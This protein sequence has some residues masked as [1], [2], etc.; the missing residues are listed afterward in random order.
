M[1]TYSD[2]PQG[3]DEW[4]AERA[5]LLTASNAKKMM[6]GKTTATYKS[7]VDDLWEERV[8]G[9]VPSNGFVSAAMVE[10]SEREPEARAALAWD[11]N[12]DIEEVGLA[13]NSSYPGAGA[14]LDGLIDGSIGVEIKVRKLSRLRD[15][16]DYTHQ[17]MFQMMICD[18]EAVYYWG[19]PKLYPNAA[20]Q[21]TPFLHLIERDEDKIS[22]MRERY[23]ETNKLINEK[24]Q[25]EIDRNE[26]ETG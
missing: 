24:A 17:I 19:Y 18:L 22:L 8:C 4:L 15:W 5:G 23:L 7:Y 14:S 2:I 11:L 10:G 25:K 16:K 13:T 9:Y 12:R 26:H 1:I 21:P 3:S 6:A 20:I